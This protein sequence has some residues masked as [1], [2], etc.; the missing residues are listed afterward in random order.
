MVGRQIRSVVQRETVDSWRSEVELIF[1]YVKKALE[2]TM[3]IKIL[4]GPESF[5]GKITARTTDVSSHMLLH[6]SDVHGAITVG[7]DR[8]IQQLRRVVSVADI[9]GA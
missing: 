6:D 9:T 4:S 7:D 3:E 1:A 5:C 8:V 2:G